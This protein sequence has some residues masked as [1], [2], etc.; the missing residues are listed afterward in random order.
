MASGDIICWL[1]SDDWL[2]PEAFHR[3]AHELASGQKSVVMGK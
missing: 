3:V 2:A 1:N